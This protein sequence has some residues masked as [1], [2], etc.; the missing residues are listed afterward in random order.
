MIG[1]DCVLKN[2]AYIAHNLKQFLKF[3]YVEDRM[4]LLIV[5][6]SQLIFINIH[7]LELAL[8][9]LRAL[10]PYLGK[11]LTLLVQAQRCEDYMSSLWHR[12]TVSFIWGWIMQVWG[13]MTSSGGVGR[14]G[15]WNLS[16][17]CLKD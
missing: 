11:H 9:F 4:W 2:G 17:I 8:S 12:E 16:K 15:E 13:R 7:S 1:I 5:A 6:F 10:I 3:C 14:E